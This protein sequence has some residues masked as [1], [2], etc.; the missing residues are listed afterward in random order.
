MSLPFDFN[1]EAPSELQAAY[2]WYDQLR[3]GLA[4]DFAASV[5]RAFDAITANPVGYGVTY[6]D[7]RAAPVSGFPYAVCYRVL[8]NRVRILAVDH[9]SRDPATWQSRK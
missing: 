6:L 5:D 2:E 4:D 9:T 7:I 3:P 8:R 1:P